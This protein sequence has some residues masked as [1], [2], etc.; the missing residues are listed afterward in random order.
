MEKLWAVSLE[1]SATITLTGNVIHGGHAASENDSTYGIRVAC[2]AAD[3]SI[4][5]KLYNN[6]IHA[7]C[8]PGTGYGMYLV[9]ADDTFRVVNNIILGDETTESYGL[10]IFEGA[11][12]ARFEANTFSGLACS[13][14][15]EAERKD[16]LDGDKGPGNEVLKTAPAFV[17]P[18]AGDYHLTAQSPESLRTGGADLQDKNVSLDRDGL[19]R[20]GSD[21]TYSRG[22]Y[23]FE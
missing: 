6:T 19:A 15:P 3:E 20:P 5:A 1:Q 17:D 21:G 7:G 22:A 23:E 14:A 4:Q 8:G 9:D 11:T 13:V 2:N 12:P 10:R 16:L 18:D